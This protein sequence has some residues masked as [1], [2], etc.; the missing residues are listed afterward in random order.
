MT[1]TY[2]FSIV[3]VIVTTFIL[4]QVFNYCY[5]IYLIRDLSTANPEEVFRLV[6]YMHYLGDVLRYSFANITKT[7]WDFIRIALSS[8][9]LSAS[10]SATHWKMPHVS[11]LDKYAIQ[12]LCSHFNIKLFFCYE[13]RLASS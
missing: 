10:K 12:A 2:P 11:F 6:D 7:G 13:I 1:R 3:I 9:V 5:L 8:W 4:Q